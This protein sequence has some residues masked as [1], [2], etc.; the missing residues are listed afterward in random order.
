MRARLM[1]IGDVAAHNSAQ[2]CR[3]PRTST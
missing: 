1:V 2:V 3:S